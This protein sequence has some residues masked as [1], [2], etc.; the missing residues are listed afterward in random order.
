M[1]L[2]GVLGEMVFADTPGE[3]VDLLDLATHIHVG[4]ATSFGFGRLSLE[5]IA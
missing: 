4:K 2:E 3:I 1:P 5:M